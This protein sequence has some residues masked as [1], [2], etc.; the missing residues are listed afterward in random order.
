MRSYSVFF[1]FVLFFSVLLLCSPP[2][3]NLLPKATVT[4]TESLL[5]FENGNRN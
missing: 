1:V 3:S 4:T 5:P 2:N